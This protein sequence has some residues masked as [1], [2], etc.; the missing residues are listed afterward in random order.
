MTSIRVGWMAGAGGH[1]ASLSATPSYAIWPSRLSA[2]DRAG[3][4]GSWQ[5][6]AGPGSGW[7]TVDLSLTIQ[8]MEALCW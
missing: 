7:S 6:A 2:L 5:L 3:S 1:G 4:F 8:D